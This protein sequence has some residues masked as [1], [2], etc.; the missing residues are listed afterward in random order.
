M[1]L[2][3]D[4]RNGPGCLCIYFYYD[5]I[6]LLEGKR[7]GNEGIFVEKILI[8]VFTTCFFF[9]SLLLIAYRKTRGDRIHY[10]SYDT[11]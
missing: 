11:V 10:K 6:V 5:P 4:P 8:C 9:L 2:S 7:T 3:F 1:N